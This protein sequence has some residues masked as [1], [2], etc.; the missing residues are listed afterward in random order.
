MDRPNFLSGLLKVK[1]NILMSFGL[2]LII[3]VGLLG[4]YFSWGRIPGSPFSNFFGGLI[5]LKY[6]SCSYD[7]GV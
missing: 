3:A 4:E 2:I 7:S 6:F 1:P 5:F